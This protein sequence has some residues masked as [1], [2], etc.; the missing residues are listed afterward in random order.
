M[1]L[2]LQYMVARLTVTDGSVV[3]V[4][5]PLAEPRIAAAGLCLKDEQTCALSAFPSIYSLMASRLSPSLASA[6]T[7]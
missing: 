1:L 7:T 2:R 3:T 6:A 5:E 4:G